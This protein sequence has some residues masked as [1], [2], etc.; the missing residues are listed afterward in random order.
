MYLYLW[1]RATGLL[2][3]NRIA[4]LVGYRTLADLHEDM[5]SPLPLA[6]VQV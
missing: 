5:R 1:W 3:H 2:H 4:R 6:N